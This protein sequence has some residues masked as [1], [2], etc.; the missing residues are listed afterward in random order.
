MQA[1]RPQSRVLFLS[2]FVFGKRY[3]RREVP[4]VFGE[5]GVMIG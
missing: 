5:K 3:V 4:F 2:V 1:K